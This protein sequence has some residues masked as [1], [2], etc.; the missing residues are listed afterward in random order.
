MIVKT[1]RNNPCISF[2][3]FQC[4]DPSP[5]S[6]G[7]NGG[8]DDGDHDDHDDRGGGLPSVLYDKV[9]EGKV[10]NM[11]VCMSVRARVR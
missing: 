1:A 2:K 8:D 11:Y 5:G 9:C 3:K 4:A 6:N 7:M 10:Y